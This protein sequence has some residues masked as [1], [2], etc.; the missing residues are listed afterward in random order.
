M[1]YLKNLLTQKVQHWAI[2]VNGEAINKQYENVFEKVR[3]FGLLMS[4]R[5]LL[6]YLQRVC[7]KLTITLV[8]FVV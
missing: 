1:M 8:L 5:P 3:P 2:T 6:S 7:L 4:P